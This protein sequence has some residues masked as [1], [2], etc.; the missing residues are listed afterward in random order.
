MSTSKTPAI[1]KQTLQ[2]ARSGGFRRFGLVFGLAG[3][4]I[5]S[6]TAGALLAA[7]LATTPLL[8]SQLSPEDAQAFGQD[9]IS[10]DTNF[11]IPQLTRPV[12][13]L[14]LGVKVLTS[15]VSDPS[16]D[17]DDLGYHALVDSFEGLSDTNLLIRFN[18]D[19]QRLAVLSLPRDTRVRLDG[20]GTTKLN[21]ANY[22]GGPA[23]TAR[24]TSE[25]LGGVGIDR[26]VRINVQGVEK[27][28]DALG[29]VEVYVP[30]DMKYQDDSQH[31]YIDLKEGEQRLDG[32]QALQFLRF[33]H[34]Q[35]GD[36]GRIQRQ[37][38]LMRALV[39]QALSPATLARLPRILSVIQDHVDTNLSIEE[40]VALV[41]FAAQIDR[42]DVQM[43]MLPGDFGVSGDE[44]SYWLPN[45]DRIDE[46]VAQYFN[47]SA[48]SSVGDDPAYLRIAIQDTTGRNAA[49][50]RMM[51]ALN[52][53]GYSNVSVNVPWNEPLDETHIIA[54]SGDL[55]DAEAVREALGVG[56]VRVENT[57][58]LE[59]DVTIQLGRDWLEKMRE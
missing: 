55:A 31:L 24:A 48:I 4:A 29:G 38:L 49:V 13:V 32:E 27:L 14:V 1:S 18:P 12:N 59:S 25:L 43:L 47:D 11:S 26:Y 58:E 37:Q 51:N 34:D 9:D 40:L 6:A 2:S 33:R 28:V 45:Y 52:D 54:Q 7:A 5:V 3:V 35:Y 10:T 15:D 56:E 46:I 16:M 21:A 8:Q 36:I 30:Y 22:Y 53:A 57:G 42:S 50:D 20:I 23:M 41:G 39:E 44:Y 19:G 17:S